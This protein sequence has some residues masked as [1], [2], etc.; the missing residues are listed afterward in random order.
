MLNVRSVKLSSAK[1]V[2]ITEESM[3]EPLRVPLVQRLVLTIIIPSIADMSNR[4]L[5]CLVNPAYRC[6]HCGA[7]VCEDH[8]DFLAG[9]NG[10]RMIPTKAN[11]NHVGDLL[12]EECL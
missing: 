12:N 6:D 7:V 5:C 3:T 2:G 9:F 10:E 1:I 4:Y 8:G 11:T